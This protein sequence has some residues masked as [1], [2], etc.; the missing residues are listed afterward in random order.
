MKNLNAKITA[1]GK[2]VPEKVLDNFDFEEMVDT[3]DK[4]IRDRTGIVERHIAADDEASSDMGSKAFADM[5][6]RFDVDPE[7]IDLILVATITPDMFFPSTAALIQDN[8]GAKNAWGFDLS[9][10]CSGFVFALENARRFIESGDYKKVL[11]FGTEKMSAITDYEDRSTCV[12]FGDAG[13]CVLLEPT[14][15][16]EG[17]LDSIVKMDGMGK[18]FLYMKGGGSRNPASHETVDKKM[19]Y[20][21]QNGRPVF[22][23]AVNNMVDAG[24][25]L[26]ERNGVS[27]QDLSLFIPHQANKRIIDACAS[28]LDLDDD[29]VMI[30]IDKYGN[31]TAATIP[32]GIIDA[33]DNSRLDKNDL[34]LLTAFGGGFTWGAILLKWSIEQ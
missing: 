34:A 30:N 17:V 27:N 10:A 33:Y 11:V 31:T 23:Y 7:E 12:L 8:I 21:Y 15:D 18:D 26:I 9:A 2:Y 29:Q 24:T 22:K 32:L 25:E 3:T 6:E 1:F 28:R 14:E 16:E 13:T 5:Q 20:I 4:W 19:H